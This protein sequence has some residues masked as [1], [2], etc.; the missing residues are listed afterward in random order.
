[1]GKLI[2]S[3]NLNKAEMLMTGWNIAKSSK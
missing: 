1:M 2:K 3:L